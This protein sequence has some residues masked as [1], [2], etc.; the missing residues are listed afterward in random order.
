MQEKSVSANLCHSFI[1]HSFFGPFI[2]TNEKL[3][4][5]KKRL[6][7]QIWRKQQKM[8][9]AFSVFPLDKGVFCLCLFRMF[10]TGC[11]GRMGDWNLWHR[12]AC[13]KV[14]VCM[15]FFCSSHPWSKLWW[16][17]QSRALLWSQKP[18]REND[19]FNLDSNLARIY[20]ISSQTKRLNLLAH[21]SNQV[22]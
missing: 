17:S 1:G 18:P 19:S 12:P 3:F 20:Q 15:G 8:G 10:Q 7:S 6:K 11:R 22:H 14:C 4:S 5:F 16:Q 13:S 21:T 9:F 2:S